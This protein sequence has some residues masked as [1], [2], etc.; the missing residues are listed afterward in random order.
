MLKALADSSSVLMG[1]FPSE[2]FLLVIV[3]QAHILQLYLQILDSTGSLSMVSSVLSKS[4][5]ARSASDSVDQ[6]GLLF[7]VVCC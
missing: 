3:H 2:R 1:S 4:A 6:H 5:M 7:G